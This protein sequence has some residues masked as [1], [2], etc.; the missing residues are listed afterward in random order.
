MSSDVETRGPGWER[1]LIDPEDATAALRERVYMTLTGLA[2]V[3]TLIYVDTRST[4]AAISSLVATMVGLAAASLVADIVAHST[5]QGEP[6]EKPELRHMLVVAGQALEL[7]LLPVLVV[8]A[9]AAG[10]WTLDTALLVAAATFVVEQ[11]LVTVL[12]IRRST[13]TGVKRFAVVLVEL[14]LCALVIVVKL[15]AH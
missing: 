15:L 10:W 14:A 13:L 9:S 12:A 7:V 6:P 2:T 3:L 8:A 11:L 5:V 4:V 1:L